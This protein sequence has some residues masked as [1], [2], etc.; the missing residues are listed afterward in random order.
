M[1]LNW[2]IMKKEYI[3]YLKKFDNK[4]Q[5]I[6][7]INKSK[8]YIGIVFNINNFNYYVPISSCKNKYYS[9][10]ENIDFVKVTEGRKILA[11]INLNNM[12]PVPEEN[13]NLLDYQNISEYFSFR[14]EI[15]KQKYI[16]LLRKEIA[17]INQRK[18]DILR[19]AKRLYELKYKFP[20]YKVSKR[21][22]NFKL[23]ERKC[24]EYHRSI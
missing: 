4:V 16:A 6:E 14:N 5:D 10:S 21:C 19:R 1:K 17:I 22:C 2:Y 18:D 23:L 7:Y 9:M 12:I 8:P 13:I 11:A 15:D 20:N 24:N 3:K